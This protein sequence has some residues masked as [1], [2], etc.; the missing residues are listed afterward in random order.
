VRDCLEVV[1]D[2]YLEGKFDGRG[3]DGLTFESQHEDG[4]CQ[5]ANNIQ[6]Q[7]RI[8]LD[9]QNKPTVF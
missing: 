8:N 6:C 9:S 1:E 4:S 2:G 7:S 5:R 3:V